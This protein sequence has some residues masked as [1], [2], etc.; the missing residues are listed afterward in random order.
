[1]SLFEHIK[2]NMISAMREKKEREL[3][4]LRMLVSAVKNKEIEKRS[5][6]KAAILSDEE[7]VGVI[8]AEV[9]KRKDAREQ[10]TKGGREDLAE[11]EFYEQ[12]VLED[13]LPQ[14][15]SDD[16]LEKIVVAAIASLGASGEKDFG[17]VMGEVMK[18]VKGQASG[19]RVSACVKN[20][21]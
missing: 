7:I 10:F 13:Y 8:R 19:E 6:G 5:G 2:E 3:L 17:R 1:M 20:R 15:M 12:A 9:K 14:E 4:V 11:K 16:D 18:K 21:L